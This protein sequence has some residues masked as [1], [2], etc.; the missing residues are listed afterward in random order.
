MLGDGEIQEGQVWEASFT[1]AR[2]NADNLTAILDYNG[3]PQF[4][5]PDES[6]YTRDKPYD[7]PAEKFQAFGWHTVECNGHDHASI[8]EAIAHAKSTRGLPTC[9]IAHTV[10][11]KGVS[12]MEGDFNWHA[13]SPS[14][15]ELAAAI[16][17]LSG[18]ADIEKAA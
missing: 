15:E 4:G 1:A 16:E 5:W 11:G 7:D 6:G 17:E 13:K 14:T 3:L 12:F 2:Y 18:D 8:A 10:K 9:I